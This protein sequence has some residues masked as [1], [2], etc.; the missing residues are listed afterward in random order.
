[1]DWLKITNWNDG[2]VDYD[3]DVFLT[4]PFQTSILT[5]RESGIN[6]TYMNGSIVLRILM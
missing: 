3:D 4:K 6:E 2:P 5:V 1:M